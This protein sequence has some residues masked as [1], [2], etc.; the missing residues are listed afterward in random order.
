[1]DVDKLTNERLDDLER[2][3]G[4]V[5]KAGLLRVTPCLQPET[6]FIL[7]AFRDIPALL[8]DRRE[9]LERVEKAERER[10]GYRWLAKR[11]CL[12]SYRDRSEYEFDRTVRILAGLDPR[13]AAHDR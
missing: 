6:D 3:H 4:S 5:T 13:E 8:A 2:S 7:A 12:P 11:L 9:L 10:D 1:M